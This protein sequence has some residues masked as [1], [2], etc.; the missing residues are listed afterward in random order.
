[1]PHEA[2][3]REEI[4]KSTSSIAEETGFVEGETEWLEN[5]LSYLI[6]SPLAVQLRT[7]LGSESAESFLHPTIKDQKKV[8]CNTRFTIPKKQG[9]Y[10]HIFY[11][12]QRRKT[13]CFNHGNRRILNSLKII[14]VRFWYETVFHNTW[15][16]VMQSF[17]NF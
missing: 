4:L 5:D 12:I 15:V 7:I 17:L 11:C 2:K 16:Q 9:K 8:K 3:S 14:A 6:Q 1:M 10:I 13:F